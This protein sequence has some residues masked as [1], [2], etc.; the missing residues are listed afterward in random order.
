M[1]KNIAISPK[2][3][4]VCPVDNSPYADK[5]YHFVKKSRIQETYESAHK[6]SSRTPLTRGPFTDAIWNNPLFL[7]LTSP[8]V[9]HLPRM[10]NLCKQSRA[11]ARSQGSTRWLTSAPVHP[12]NTSHARTI[13]LGNP[14]QLLVFKTLLSWSTRLFHVSRHGQSMF[15][16]RNNSLF[17]GLFQIAS[18]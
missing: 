18:N 6:C 11:T 10:A 7:G 12:L 1:V 2:L 3:D 5:L 15:A 13:H 8:L 17:L 16:I 4:K 9:E 14:E